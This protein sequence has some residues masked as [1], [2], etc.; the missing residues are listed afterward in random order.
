MTPASPPEPYYDYEVVEAP[1][2]TALHL[3]LTAQVTTHGVCLSWEG[4]ASGMAAGTL[5]EAG[6]VLLHSLG[7]LLGHPQPVPTSDDV[8]PLRPR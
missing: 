2:A 6:Q 3:R 1:A 5:A 4:D 8:T 7:A